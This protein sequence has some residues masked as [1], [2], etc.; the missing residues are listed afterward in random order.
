[1]FLFSF[2]SAVL[3][4]SNEINE[5]WL[6]AI[7]HGSFVSCSG[8]HIHSHTQKKN[9]TVNNRYDELG[10]SAPWPN[11]IL[12][13][14]LN[15]HLF[16]FTVHLMYCRIVYIDVWNTSYAHN[17]SPSHRWLADPTPKSSSLS[18][19]SLSWPLKTFHFH[20]VFFLLCNKINRRVRMW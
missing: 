3:S 17:N 6:F 10:V 9:I 8:A 11:K 15:P 19:P 12:K 14:R 20:Y 7:I 18:R 2:F 13:S 5:T 16:R 4:R 1:M